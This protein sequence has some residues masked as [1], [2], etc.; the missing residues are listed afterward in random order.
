[1]F[2][3]HLVSWI[4]DYLYVMHSKS[5]A[6]EILDDTDWQSVM[7]QIKPKEKLNIGFEELQLLHH[8]QVFIAFPQGAVSSSGQ[9]MT[10]RPS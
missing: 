1:M 2:K 7:Y 6:N 8:F 3:D 9:E 4:H 5:R 10:Q